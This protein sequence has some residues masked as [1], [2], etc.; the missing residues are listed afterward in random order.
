MS[1][2]DISQVKHEDLFIRLSKPLKNM[3]AAYLNDVAKNCYK[4]KYMDEAVPNFE[5]VDICHKEK[6]RKYF[7]TFEEKMTNIRDSNRFRF[8][9]CTTAAE[10]D[11]VK[12]V[13]CI[14]EYNNGMDRDNNTIVSWFES[15]SKFAK[16]C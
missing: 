12:A 15:Q 6:Y 1:P 8:Q 7:G 14:R 10:N 2:A 4:E 5:Q 16:Y 3:Q 11:I 13:D 9:D